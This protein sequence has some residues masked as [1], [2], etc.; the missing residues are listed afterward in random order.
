LYMGFGTGMQN[1]FGL[2]GDNQPLDDSCGTKD[3]EGCSV[4]ILDWHLTTRLS[5]VSFSTQAH[6]R[7]QSA[8]QKQQARR[9]GYAR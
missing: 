6:Q 5:L 7:G 2:W 3:P 1:Q 8:S 9:L 4:V